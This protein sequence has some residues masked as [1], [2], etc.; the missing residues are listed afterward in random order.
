MSACPAAP[1]LATLGQLLSRLSFLFLTCHTRCSV[2]Y[3]QRCFI[4]SC[5]LCS[6]AMIYCMGFAA[7]AKKP[8]PQ[9][10]ARERFILQPRPGGVAMRPLAPSLASGPE[11][12]SHSHGSRP[13]AR[14]GHAWSFEGCCFSLALGRVVTWPPVAA[15]DTLVSGQ[16]T[17]YPV[18]PWKKRGADGCYVSP[19][20]VPVQP[21]AT[22]HLTC[23]D[24]GHLPYP[25]VSLLNPG[26]CLP[27]LPSH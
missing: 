23:S 16:V 24:P 15:R 21:E 8:Q 25:T 3:A 2:R 5:P 4:S 13:G 18:L 27:A 19:Q 7:V 1:W 6:W 10:H 22:V 17:T 12:C 11:H 9:V 26:P 20:F 14:P